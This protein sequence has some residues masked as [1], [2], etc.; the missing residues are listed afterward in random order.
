MDEPTARLLLD[1]YLEDLAE[2]EARQKRKQKLG[3]KADSE[4][5]IDLLKHDIAKFQNTLLDQRIAQSFAV[6]V[7]QDAAAISLLMQDEETAAQDHRLAYELDEEHQY[8]R[9]I[10]NTVKFSNPKT[11]V[12]GSMAELEL[13]MANLRTYNTLELSKPGPSSSSKNAVE[14]ESFTIQQEI[15]I[16]CE[17]VK[18][19]FDILQA[20]CG[21]HYCRECIT[22]VVQMSIQQESLYPPKCCQIEI[23]ISTA[24]DFLAPELMEQFHRKGEEFSTFNRTYCCHPECSTFIPQRKIKHGVASCPSCHRDTCAICKEGS[25]KNA[26]CPFDPDQQT[27]DA[28]AVEKSWKKCPACQRRIELFMGCNHITLVIRDAVAVPNSVTSAVPNGAPASVLVGTRT[29][30]WKRVVGSIT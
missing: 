25:H 15:C 22:A 16:I 7:H 2:I 12:A 29:I 19:S 14:H 30:C 10:T 5:A 4:I 1:F 27:M 18:H 26:D 13:V 28:L 17:E 8:K 3:E 24:T 9:P 23:P 11:T 20:S 6:A 21:H